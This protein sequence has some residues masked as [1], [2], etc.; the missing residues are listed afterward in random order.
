[1]L[2]S[3]VPTIGLSLNTKEVLTDNNACIAIAIPST[4][5]LKVDRFVGLDREGEEELPNPDDMAQF[6]DNA[7]DSLLSTEDKHNC[8]IFFRADSIAF[9]ESDSYFD[10]LLTEFS[11]SLKRR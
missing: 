11:N 5:N 1:M 2:F 3:C 7:L 10:D 6:T 8:F 9:D 4:T